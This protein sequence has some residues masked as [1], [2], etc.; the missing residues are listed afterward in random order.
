MP[1]FTIQAPDGRKIRIEAP[2]ESTAMRGA[3]EWVSSNPLQPK[4]A[5]PTTATPE[6][7]DEEMRRVMG[8]DWMGGAAS[9]NEAAPQPAAPDPDV[10]SRLRSGR[11]RFSQLPRDQQEAIARSERT[12]INSTV[13]SLARGIPFLGGALDE[14]NAATA[15]ASGGLIG[16]SQAPSYGERYEDNIAYERALDKT[17]DADRPAASLAGRV[18][19]GGAATLAAAPLVAGAGAASAVGRTALG[20]GARSLPGAVARG[21]T[22]GLLQGAAAGAGE[23]EGGFVDRGAGAVVG[24]G[25]GAGLGAAL[26]L[27]VGVGTAL[28]NRMRGNSAPLSDVSRP[29]RNYVADKVDPDSLIRQQQELARLGPQAMLADVSPEF[30]GVARGLAARPGSRGPVVE[31]LLDR[32]AGSNA[33]LRD[34]VISAVGNARPADS[35]QNAFRA[36][37]EALSSRYA[38]ALKDAA[39]VD[40]MS[41]LA[42]VDRLSRDAKGETARALSKARDLLATTQNLPAGPVRVPDVSARGMLNARQELDGLIAA[43]AE[44]PESRNAVRSLTMVRQQLDGALTQAV[45]G[46]KRLDNAFAALARQSEAA[47][48]GGGIM[49]TGKTALNPATLREQQLGMIPAERRAMAAGTR[50]ELDRIMGTNGNDAQAIRRNIRGS[51]AAGDW[52]PQKLQMV[53]GREPAN[54]VMG[55]V[56]REVAFQNTANRITGGSDTGMTRDFADFLKGLETPLRL[57]GQGPQDAIGRAIAAAN[58]ASRTLGGSTGTRRA[59]RATE[60]FV[61]L[62]T[63]RGTQRDELIEQLIRL[64][65]EQRRVSGALTPA[66]QSGLS[67]GREG[68]RSSQSQRR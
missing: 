21:A 4:S 2:D 19:G 58:L 42:V 49:A 8:G 6:A 50:A 25:I 33:R 15:A 17:F 1:I 32:T 56:D 11:A 61:K 35:I 27:V 36:S 64:A 46:L 45:P 26:P 31:A 7:P 47:T 51:D 68:A 52:N 13:R 48:A 57:P 65:D 55:A 53:F 22:A 18:A 41:A 9:A 34:D 30:Q 20:L 28:A 5:N 60:D 44:N 12:G 43:V 54:R 24:G 29:V 10:V 14:M 62:V 67:L 16:G 63:A 66:I 39:P 40:T 37:Q 23:A 3:Q 59:E 38:R